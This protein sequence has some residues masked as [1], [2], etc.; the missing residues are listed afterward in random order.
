MVKAKSKVKVENKGKTCTEI[1][2]VINVKVQYKKDIRL[3]NYSNRA[4]MWGFKN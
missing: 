4:I 2:I 1:P 3:G